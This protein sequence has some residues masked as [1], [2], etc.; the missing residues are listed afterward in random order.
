MGAHYFCPTANEF[1]LCDPDAIGKKVKC[2]ACEEEH[3]AVPTDSPAEIQQAMAAST[4]LENVEQEKPK[5]IS[6]TGMVVA[7]I[8][9][10]SGFAIFSD[11]RTL[12]DVQSAILAWVIG[13]TLFIRSFFAPIRW[14]QGIV[15]FFGAGFIGIGITRLLLTRDPIG[16][17]IMM[18]LITFGCAAVLLFFGFKQFK[19]K[20]K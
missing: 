4:S 7:I 15:T 13:I 10:L 19:K 17:K 3:D 2:S 18:L 8:F 1:I 14:W 12:Q 9:F 11:K 20:E 5:K 16:V 6:K